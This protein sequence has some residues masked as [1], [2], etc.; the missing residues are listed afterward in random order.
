MQALTGRLLTLLSMLIS[1][2]FAFLLGIVGAVVLWNVLGGADL[3]GWARLGLSLMAIPAVPGLWFLFL[4]ILFGVPRAVVAGG[5][6]FQ[7]W[8]D[9]QVKL[10]EEH[11]E[12]FDAVGRQPIDRVI[13]SGAAVTANDVT[14]T[15]IAV[16]AGSVGGDINLIQTIRRESDDEEHS[17]WDLIAELEDD[18]GTSYVLM[19]APVEMSTVGART[20]IAFIPGIPAGA[21]ELRLTIQKLFVL[22]EIEGTPG[23]WEF[24]IPLTNSRENA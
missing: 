14:I 13:P 12:A 9:G 5:D 15:L 2:P 10:W 1:P 17:L 18:V 20:H 6:E 7:Q 3:P 19:A 8:Q 16:A 21:S 4:P 22:G 24:N 23:P 11:R